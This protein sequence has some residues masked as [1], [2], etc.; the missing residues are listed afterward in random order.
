MINF[1]K[2]DYLK[3]GNSRQQKAYKTLT[4]LNIFSILKDY[5]PI[6][7]GTIPIEIDIP[8]SDLDI[9]CQCNNHEVFI[10]LVE[11]NFKENRQF[12]M[13]STT[14]NNIKTSI[15]SFKFNDFDIEIF[16][17]NRATELQHAYRHMLIEYKI[18]QENN[19]AFKSDIIALK[20]NGFKTEPAFA[21]LL[22]L[23]GNPYE[24]LLYYFDN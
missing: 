6:L 15:C 20:Q 5:N 11:Q 12:N 14:V 23:K 4:A 8:E 18:L 1:K 19:M 2:I 16:A 24:A 3:L 9:I 13:Y 10:E 7:T 22:G 17:Q 21:K